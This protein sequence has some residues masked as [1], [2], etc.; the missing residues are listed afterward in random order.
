VFV[1]IVLF[2]VAGSGDEVARRNV[3]ESKVM[4]ARIVAQA[5]QMMADV[6]R[7]Y[8]AR[9]RQVVAR[10]QRWQRLEDWLLEDGGSQLMWLQTDE[11]APVR[12]ANPSAVTANGT[13]CD[14][15]W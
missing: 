4:A 11:P 14:G 5:E 13:F 8:A 7:E 2:A 9:Q 6:D 15:D 10:C 1:A 12:S 3:I